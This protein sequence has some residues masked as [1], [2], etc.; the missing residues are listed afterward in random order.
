MK[1]KFF[2]HPV[3][4]KTLYALLTICLLACLFFFNAV[5]S[6]LSARYPLALDLTRSAAYQLDSQTL[7]LLDGL[8][9]EVRIEVLAAR[10]SFEGNPYL[11]QARA[12]L[13]QYPRHSPQVSLRFVDFEA[14][15]AFAAGY[16][17]L[18]LAPGNILVS[19]G[20]DTRQLTLNELFN[21][22]YSQASATGTAV[23]SSRAQEALS[24]AILQVTSDSK[25]SL[26]LLTGAGTTE[27][28][29]LLRLL[30][31][32]NYA[33]ST[34]NLAAGSLQEADLLLLLAPTVDL[35]LEAL[36]RLDAY[37]YNEGQYGKTLL[38]FLD[39]GQPALPQLEAF[40]S[41]WGAMP[42]D[43][44]VYETSQDKT[45]SMQPFY[46]LA[47]YT[48]TAYASGMRDASRPVL[49][50]RAKPFALLFASKDR[51]H[52]REL[53]GFSHSAGVR[54]SQ[55]GSDFN[56]ATASQRGPLP[57]M[58]LLSRRVQDR[59]AGRQLASHILL[60]ASTAMVDAQM[61]ENSQLGNA[62]YLLTLLSELTGREAGVQ[63][64]PISLA[65]QHLGIPSA[66][67]SLWGLLLSAL[68]PGALLIAGIATWLFRRHQ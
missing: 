13:E 20:S 41:E 34:R 16:P 51:Q 3:K 58:A 65:A 49:L 22:T 60:S 18:S 48:D 39:A 4:T 21:Y 29:A 40:L 1:S 42:Q 5:L 46:P 23:A 50:P 6:L 66:T 63:V 62:D 8:H 32:N 38:I 12:M 68:L 55:A 19:S 57:A 9:Q 44:A 67:A 47:A 35:S 53:L 30:Q 52:T 25:R 28:P 24:S 2:A 14:E 15:P 27:A 11:V 10:D 56:P 26:A 43:G 59:Q 61:L 37:L 54:P 17:Q 36:G 33:L 45:F 7:A 64:R 31:D